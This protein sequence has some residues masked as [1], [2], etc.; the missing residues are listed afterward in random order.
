[1]STSTLSMAIASPSSPPE[2]RRSFFSQPN[3]AAS[4]TGAETAQPTLFGLPDLLRPSNFIQL[5]NA[6][7]RDCDEVRRALALSLSSRESDDNNDP[8]TLTSSLAVNNNKVQTA[9]RTLHRLDDISNIVCT[10]GAESSSTGIF[11][12]EEEDESAQFAGYF[13][14]ENSIEGM[15]TLVRDMF[16]ITMEEAAI[17][18]EERWDID[19]TKTGIFDEATKAGGGGMRKFEFHH[20]EDGPLGTMYFNLH[21][22]NG[23]F[24]HAAHFTIRC[25]RIRNEDDDIKDKND[26]DHQLPA[27]ALVCN[28][29]PSSSSPSQALLSHSEVETLY[30]EFGHGL[31]SLSRQKQQLQHEHAWCSST[32][33]QCTILT[34]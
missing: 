10:D 33:Y 24:V 1:M 15:K 12:G 30:H 31:H 3:P 16:G 32:S 6:A 26:N 21:P 8:T 9:K 29:S 4:S 5:A 34:E 25:G 20:E 22:R 2:T 11:G 17:P 23:K 28:L 13:T 27:V 18:I 14:V 19:T 7:V